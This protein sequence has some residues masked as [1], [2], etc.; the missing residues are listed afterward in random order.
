[1]ASPKKE[2]AAFE[3]RPL[4]VK[5]SKMSSHKSKSKSAKK[6]KKAPVPEMKNDRTS[7]SKDAKHSKPSRDPMTGGY[8]IPLEPVEMQAAAPAKK[9][10][11]IAS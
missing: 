4:S 3:A 2:K 9:S 5:S 6:D 11:K 10:H 7:R 1:M 8:L